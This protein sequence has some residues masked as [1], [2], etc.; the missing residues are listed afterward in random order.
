MISIDS[1]SSGLISFNLEGDC[2][3]VSN[4]ME[5]ASLLIRIPSTYIT[6]SLER[7]ALLEP[8][9]LIREPMP[10]EPPLLEI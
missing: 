7:D 4:E 5:L 3:P 8:L 2:P 10:V 1:I 6:G 9:T